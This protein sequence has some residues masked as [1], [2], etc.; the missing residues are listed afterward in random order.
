MK[1]ILVYVAM[2]LAVMTLAVG[3]GSLKE[4]QNNEVRNIH[5]T[6]ES[7]EY[8]FKV[9]SYTAR[10]GYIR[11]FLDDD[12]ISYITLDSECVIFVDNSGFPVRFTNKV[13][14]LK[15]N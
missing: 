15:V 9:K 4:T 6:I 10:N 13:Y 11:Y 2:L 7:D 5:L 14:D 1:N 8:D 12:N 3:C